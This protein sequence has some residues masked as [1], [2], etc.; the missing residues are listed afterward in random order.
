MY[1]LALKRN[2]DID[3]WDI[4]VNTFSGTSSFPFRK[5]VPTCLI[6]WPPKFAKAFHLRIYSPCTSSN[7]PPALLH[8]TF[9][10]RIDPYRLVSES[11]PNV[12]RSST[13]LRVA[14]FRGSL[15]HPRGNSRGTDSLVSNRRLS[16]FILCSIYDQRHCLSIDLEARVL[17]RSV[18]KMVEVVSHTY[19]RL[20]STRRRCFT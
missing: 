16:I 5:L 4:S 7:N 15:S 1:S 17:G 9:P 3:I 11:T 12:N 19:T 14:C 13:R 2:S 10:N 6:W 18:L 20:I 8:I